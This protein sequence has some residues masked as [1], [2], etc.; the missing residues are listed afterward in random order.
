MTALKF[1]AGRTGRGRTQWL[2]I[3][4]ALPLPWLLDIPGRPRSALC[5]ASGLTVDDTD[6]ALLIVRNILHSLGSL[7]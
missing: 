3:L 2:L 4:P 1:R 6:P 7:R 5:Q